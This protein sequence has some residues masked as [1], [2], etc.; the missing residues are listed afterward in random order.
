MSGEIWCPK[1]L[2]YT[3]YG[4]AVDY[5]E[6]EQIRE[7]GFTWKQCILLLDLFT[8]TTFVQCISETQEAET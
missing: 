5:T 6:D 1:A 2:L 8:T 7:I 4:G 3:L